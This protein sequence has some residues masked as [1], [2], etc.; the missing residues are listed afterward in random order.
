MGRYEIGDGY[1]NVGVI[2]PTKK[3]ERNDYII[4]FARIGWLVMENQ[5]WKEVGQRS[6]NPKIRGS[7]L[8]PKFNLFHKMDKI[9]IVVPM[10]AKHGKED[11]YLHIIKW[12]NKR[13]HG[14]AGWARSYY[15]FDVDK[16]YD[17]VT[18]AIVRYKVNK[19]RFFD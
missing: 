2:L 5:Y 18:K 1:V 4:K 15:I 3:E 16:N 12:R 19:R 11:P 9:G 7:G 8:V 6:D 13:I 10:I 14:I 17:P